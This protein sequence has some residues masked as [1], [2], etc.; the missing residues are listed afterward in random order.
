MQSHSADRRAEVEQPRLRVAFMPIV[1]AAPLLYAHSHGFFRRNG[2]DVTLVRAPSWSGCKELLVYAHVDAAHLL[3]AMPLAC[4]LGIDGRQADLRLIM[5]QNVNGQALT[6][7][8]KHLGPDV[9]KRMKGF[10]LGV[11][12]RFSMHYYLLAHWLA[13][14][15]IDPLNDVKILEVTPPRM[16]Y[17]LEKGWLDGYLAPEPFNQLAVQRGIGFIEL[18]SQEIWSGHPCCSMATRQD[19]IDRC[20]R[21]YTALLRSLLEAQAELHRAHAQERV[22][23]A[24]EI[25]RPEYLNQEATPIAQ[26][27]NGA[28]PD[29]KGNQL[30]AVDHIDFVPYPREEFGSWML[31]QMQRW[32]QL[33]GEVDYRHTVQSVFRR[34]VWGLAP[35]M[36]FV[37]GKPPASDCLGLHPG[38]DP[39]AFMRGQPFSAFREATPSVV[40]YGLSPAAGERLEAI[41]RQLAFLAGGEPWPPLQI[42]S[43]DPL[44]LLE[45]MLN[46]TALN[47][48]FTQES[49]AEEGENLERRV[50]QRTTEL[51]NEVT[52]RRQVEGT[53]ARRAAE[54]TA[55]NRELE[56]FAYSVAHDLRTPL[57][58]ISGFSQILLQDHA[59]QLSSDALHC[60]DRICAS[61]QWMG[62]IIDKLLELARLC[63]RTIHWEPMNLSEMVRAIVARLRAEEPRREVEIVVQSDLTA[64]GDASLI[65]LVLQHLLENAWKFTA[66][67]SRATIQFGAVA[68]PPPTVYFVRDNGAGF[69]AR[70]ADKLFTPFERLHSVTD[71]PGTGIG[72]A[73][74]RRIVERHGGRVWGEG[75]VDQGAVF[76]F[77]LGLGEIRS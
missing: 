43:S 13:S 30:V 36:G 41:V 58:S 59:A 44:G 45:Q 31:S 20:P 21:S 73:T 9:R 19:F 3:S 52:C 68:G 38:D 46:E 32:G 1:C 47:L 15:G 66:R 17:Y 67:R 10:V 64:E 4:A 75:T 16:P 55:S 54:L 22:A 56:A 6:L 26:A 37:D 24:Q 2:L 33:P 5:V 27:L 71:F 62:E 76:Y 74:V 51:E 35:R 14:N 65:G 34:E 40:D 69:D 72:L 61:S 48:R 50:H 28:F 63:R 8:C 70:Y 7:A 11:P 25:A 60:L 23:I 42:T 12:Y 77:T 53:L 18:L 49:L 39:A 57:R 29:G